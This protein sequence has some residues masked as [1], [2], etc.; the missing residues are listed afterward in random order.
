MP[1]HIAKMSVAVYTTLAL[2]VLSA[3]FVV[4]P[5]KELRTGSLHVQVRGR[6]RDVSIFACLTD[7]ASSA[8]CAVHAAG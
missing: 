2:V 7:T 3:S 6:A 8:R 5:V 4:V 1:Q